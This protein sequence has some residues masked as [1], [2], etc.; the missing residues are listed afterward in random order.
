MKP[1]V[2]QSLTVISINIYSSIKLADNTILMIVTF[3]WSM[4]DISVQ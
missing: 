3:S 1:E 4:T 2:I